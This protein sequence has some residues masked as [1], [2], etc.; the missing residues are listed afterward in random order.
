MA[1]LPRPISLGVLVLFAAV[2]RRKD[3]AF[4]TPSLKPRRLAGFGHPE[5]LRGSSHTRDMRP[6]R[7]RAVESHSDAS[8]SQWQKAWKAILSLFGGVT[9]GVG[10]YLLFFKATSSITSMVSGSPELEIA[11]FV[12]L[13]L[14]PLILVQQGAVEVGVVEPMQTL[15]SCMPTRGLKHIIQSAIPGTRNV[16]VGVLLFFSVN[17]LASAAPEKAQLALPEKFAALDPDGNGVLT[18]PEFESEVRKFTVKILTALFYFE[19]GLFGIT[20]LQKPDGYPPEGRD[21]IDT[22][23]RNLDFR[24]PKAV[25]LYLALNALIL[26]STVSGVLR[27]WGLSPSHI[28]ALGGV[29]GLAFGLASQ[30][31]VGNFMSGI[32]LIVNRQF[33]V[34]DFIETNNIKGKVTKMGWTFIEIESGDDLV[35][36]PNV[37]VVNAMITQ[38]GHY[39]RSSKPAAS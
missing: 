16:M 18:G 31:L 9:F 32:L 28:L 17:L 20:S 23:W 15:A 24:R 39:S 12:L 2:A 30:N 36:L 34:G 4:S 7:T 10:I 8:M 38:I 37:M 3:A 19:C 11:S 1:R 29:G 26:M 21:V 13:S 33:S 25:V 6:M 27:A 5:L 22:Y 14:I 35:M